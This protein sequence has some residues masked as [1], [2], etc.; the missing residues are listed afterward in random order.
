M[1]IFNV[2]HINEEKDYICFSVNKEITDEN[3]KNLDAVGRI[4]VDSEGKA[5][6][7]L[8]ENKQGYHH[9]RISHEHW[10]ELADG[11]SVN[12]TPLLI[13]NEHDKSGK[14]LIYLW[15]EMKLL[16]DNIKGNGNY[17]TLFVEEVEKVFKQY[18]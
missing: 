15:D 17:G 3:W 10:A 4:L 5:F 12:K 9:V 1:H 8:L 18:I 2:I 6:V 13:L 16:L 11:L 14:E 7:Y